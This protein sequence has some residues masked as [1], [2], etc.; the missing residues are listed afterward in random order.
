MPHKGHS[1]SK[2]QG[3]CMCRV[4]P[5]SIARRPSRLTRIVFSQNISRSLKKTVKRFPKFQRLLSRT[6]NWTSVFPT[7]IRPQYIRNYRFYCLLRWQCRVL[8]R[9]PLINSKVIVLETKTGHVYGKRVRQ[10]STMD[11]TTCRESAITLVD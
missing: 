2:A 7:P 8:A 6:D 10:F 3:Q 9:I 1:F 5:H 4:N 11:S